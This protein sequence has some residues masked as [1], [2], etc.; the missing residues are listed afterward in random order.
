[1]RSGSPDEYLSFKAD[2]QH[3]YQNRPEVLAVTELTSPANDDNNRTE[4]ILKTRAQA[5]GVSNRPKTGLEQ[6]LKRKDVPRGYTSSKYTGAIGHKRMQSAAII[7]T[8]INASGCLDVDINGRTEVGLK[9]QKP[10]GK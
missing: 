4:H 1:M 8:K 9:S 3:Y 2:N 10:E 6:H 7:G 5:L